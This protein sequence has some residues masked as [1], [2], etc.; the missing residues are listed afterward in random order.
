MTEEEDKDRENRMTVCMGQTLLRA[1]RKA[2]GKDPSRQRGHLFS[3]KTQAR[4]GSS[5]L[6]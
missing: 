6:N 2:S 3:L 1:N 5:G 4:R